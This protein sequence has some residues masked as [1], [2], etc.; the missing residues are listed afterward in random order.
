[1]PVVVVVAVALGVEPVTA[2][3][4]AVRFASDMLEV[5][6]LTL[7]MPVVERPASDTE[8]SPGVDGEPMLDAEL[9]V[10][11]GEVAVEPVPVAEPVAVSGLDVARGAVADVLGD[12]LLD[13][14]P[15]DVLVNVRVEEACPS[16]TN[17][18]ALN[19]IA[20]SFWPMPRKPPTPTT[21]ATMLPS[22]DIK[23]SLMSPTLSLLAPYTRVPRMSDAIICATPGEA[24]GLFT[25]VGAGDDPIIE[26]PERDPDIE[27][28]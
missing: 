6:P 7:G 18:N 20:T 16:V 2:A 13:D 5:I 28:P 11:R 8:E 14:V 17:S 3:P 9:E 22:R 24:S 1:M 23:I 19:G 26:E 4:E 25:S 10:V 15:V 27:E 21:S 12:A